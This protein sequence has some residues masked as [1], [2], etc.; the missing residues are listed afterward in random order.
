MSGFPFRLIEMKLAPWAFMRETAGR[1]LLLLPV[2]VFL[3]AMILSS[4][5][6]RYL[7]DHWAVTAVLRTTVTAEEGK[8]IAGKASGLSGVLSADYMD[9]EA[10]WKE[11][12]EAY[13][14]LE[15]LRST[16]ANP[17]PGYVEIRMRPERFIESEI[18]S[19]EAA[20]KPLPEI[21]T[22]ISGAES[23]PAVMRAGRWANLVFLAGFAFLCAL[24][25]TVFRLQEKSRALLHSA[26]FD[27]LEEHGVPARRIALSRAA[28]SALVSFFIS[29]A[30]AAASVC[31]FF[32]V[33]DRIPLLRRIVGPAVDIMTSPVLVSLALFPLAASIIS[34]GASLLGWRA[35]RSG[36][37]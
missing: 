18:R 19:V 13:P 32:T 16:G 26:D 36:R 8:G 22:I 33:E 14:G 29:L 28:G 1:F 15:G 6:N 4:G 9:P 12:L 11:F 5:V 2:C 20:L 35:A 30:A 3:I 17:L 24:V 7:S 21:E 31:I 27:F 37:K 23:L 34:G 10:S 25:F